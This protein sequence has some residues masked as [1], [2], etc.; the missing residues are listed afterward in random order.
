MNK[1]F[2]PRSKMLPPQLIICSWC[3]AS[4][5]W[6]PF[7]GFCQ[8]M[9]GKKNNFN[10]PIICFFSVLQ[11]AALSGNTF[12]D[13]YLEGWLKFSQTSVCPEV[14]YMFQKFIWLD[15]GFSNQFK[16]CRE[17]GMTYAFIEFLL[18]YM[19]CP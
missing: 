1:T 13:L 9:R 17:M 6:G 3:A 2:L 19:I 18:L 12:R 11:S 4:P 10:T 14:F 5:S 7:H 8:A 16:H 15:S